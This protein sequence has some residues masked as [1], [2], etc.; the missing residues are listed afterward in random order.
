MST[1][2]D[3]RPPVLLIGGPTA[4]GKS[5]LALAIAEA[6]DAVVVSADAMTVWRGLDIGTAKPSSAERARVPHRCIDVRDL[7]G[8]FNVSDFEAEVAAARSSHPRVVVAGGTPFYLAALVRP[9]ADLPAPDPTLRRELEALADPWARLQASDPVL[10]RR[11]HPNDRVRIVRALE[12]QR[13]TG[14]PMSEVQAGPPRVPPIAAEVVWLDRDDLRERIRARIGGMVERGY[15]R[16]VETVLATG[17]DPH[18]RALRSFAYRHLVEHVL[19]ELP[20][21]EALR[22]TDRDTWR[23]AR[24]QR[25]WS[26]GLGWESVPP[27]A[28]WRAAERLW[29][30]PRS[31]IGSPAAHAASQGDH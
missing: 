29:G 15:V 27:E 11:L 8:S 3:D 4:T 20:L 5:S 6:Y 17:V 22:R 1:P 18:H 19:Q 30:P 12:V 10:A 23:L 24:K 7:D 13:L 16:E 14:R 21:D 9:M 28:A 31:P 25:T 26:R 2:V